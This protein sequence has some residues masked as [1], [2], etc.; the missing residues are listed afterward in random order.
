M[1][2]FDYPSLNKFPKTI[3]IAGEPTKT[4]HWQTDRTEIKANFPL[5][6]FLYTDAVKDY[7]KAPFNEDNIANFREKLEVPCVTNEKR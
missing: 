3:T 6:D 1:E 5:T 2:Q 4:L 7:C